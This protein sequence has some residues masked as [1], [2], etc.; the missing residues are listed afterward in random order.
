MR[1]HLDGYAALELRIERL[2]DDAHAA[3]SDDFEDVITAQST[4]QVGIVCGLQMLD[5]EIDVRAF[6]VAWHAL[7]EFVADAKRRCLAPGGAAGHLLQR[8][9]ARL[10]L[11]QMAVQPFLAFLRRFP[12]NAASSRTGEHRL[13]ILFSPIQSPQR[14]AGRARDI[15]R[16]APPRPSSRASPRPRPAT[17]RRRRFPKTPAR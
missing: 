9:T 8:G 7:I 5:R 11:F 13:V 4:E 16:L 17:I 6:V 12:A 3:A 14:A 1:Q 10:A 15:W 2:Q